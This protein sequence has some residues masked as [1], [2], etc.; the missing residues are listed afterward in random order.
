MIRLL[1]A[2]L[3]LLSP[4][5]AAAGVLMTQENALTLAFPSG[6]PARRTIYLTE[7][8]RTR[9]QQLARAR[10]ES[11]VVTYYTGQLAGGSA[12]AAFFETNIVRTMPETFMTVVDSS[13]SVRFVE[14]LA[15]Y[16]PG[17]YIP[18]E[19]W[20]AQFRG[21][22]LNDGL[23]VKREIRNVTGSTLTT[24]ALT[25]GV[26]R[27]LAIWKIIGERQAGRKDNP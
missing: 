18:P 1:A 2:T 7:A 10:M 14:L 11:L 5:F 4:V 19:R 3:I 20:L 16:E 22:Q 24:Q 12:G 8:E 17:D 27:A 26:R 21:K 15:F 23:L 6:T 13:G 9:T 25:D